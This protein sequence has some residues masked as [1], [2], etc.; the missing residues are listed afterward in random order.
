[1]LSVRPGAA[2]ASS[3]VLEIRVTGR[4]GHASNP[5]E[6]LDPVPVAAG[7]VQAIQS[8]VTRRVS[9]FD[10]AVV[11]IAKIEAGTA[12]NV[13][14]ESAHMLGTMRTLSEST[15]SLVQEELRRLVPAIASAHGASASIEF[16]MGYPV[17]VNDEDAAALVHRTAASLVGADRAI[18][19]RNPIMGAEDWSYVLQQVPG[20]MTFLGGC[21]P[22]VDPAEAPA[23][24]SNRVVFDEDA[25]ITG[26]ATH[27]ATALAALST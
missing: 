23:N 8:M 2:M 18:W 22:G 12:E 7:I 24:H 1:M 14:P 27:A 4:G 6:A 10:P 25:M 5:S 20:A 3:D 16:H 19:E 13:I 15:R 17:T 9:V 11:T 21:P 26:V